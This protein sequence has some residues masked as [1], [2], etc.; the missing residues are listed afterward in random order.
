MALSK[1]EVQAA[2]YQRHRARLLK[3][4]KERAAL[5]P[6]WARNAKLR[7]YGI[8]PAD[9]EALLEKQG[10]VCAICKG[11]PIYDTVFCVDHDHATDEVRGLLC[12]KCNAGIGQ[13]RDDPVIVK[14]ALEYLHG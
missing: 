4:T 11:P 3:A 13:L 5:N 12:R 8:T 14:A 1:Q 7:K 2:Y 9:Y 6:H 10:G